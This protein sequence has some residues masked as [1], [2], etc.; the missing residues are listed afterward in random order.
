MKRRTKRLLAY[1]LAYVL[2]VTFFVMTA[3]VIKN[4]TKYDTVA[5]YHET[6]ENN[7]I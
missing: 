7:H 4:P 6:L 5:R 1:I 3:D 2:T